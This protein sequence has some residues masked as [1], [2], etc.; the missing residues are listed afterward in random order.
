MGDKAWKQAERFAAEKILG[1][2]GRRFWANSGQD[3]DVEN[4]GVVAQVK[5]VKVCSLAALEKLAVEAE[6]QGQQRDKVGLVLVKRRG[7][8]GFPTRW[9]VVMTAEE[10]REMS[11]PLPGEQQPC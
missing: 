2:T 10:Y 5:N 4:D 7:G 3:V 1:G 9:L 8:S 11:G 6:R